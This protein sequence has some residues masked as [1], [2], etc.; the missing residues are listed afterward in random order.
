MFPDKPFEA[1]A[2]GDI[3]EEMYEEEVKIEK[4]ISLFAV[5]AVIISSLGVFGMAHFTTRQRTKEIGIRKVNGAK[6]IDVIRLVHRQSLTPYLIAIVCCLPVTYMLSLKWLD[7]FA[8][9]TSISIWE[10]IISV[11][12][13]FIVFSFPIVFQTYQ[14]SIINPVKS[15]KYE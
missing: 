11:I 9:S 3:Y 10:I 4:A 5:L 12:A 13:S 2:F 7:N 1:A 6:I 8:Y 14:A 15:L